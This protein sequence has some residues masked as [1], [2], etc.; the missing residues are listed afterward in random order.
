M[1]IRLVGLVSIEHESEAPRVLAS[2]QAQIALARLCLERPSG[3]GR[4]QLADTI[5]PDGLPSTWASALRSV[6]SR[7]RAS[8]S[9]GASAEPAVIA[10]GGR[11]LLRL[12]EDAQVDVE[13][14]EQAAFTAA[15]AHREGD[16]STAQRLATTSVSL[17]RGPFLAS[18]EGEWVESV[19]RHLKDLRVSALETASS[20]SS[21][22]GDT[23][24]ALRYAAEAVRQAPFRESAYRC[25]MTAHRLAGNRAE[26]LRI[27]Q[28]L[29]VVLAEELG[30]DPSPES[31]AAY[32]GLLDRTRLP[33]A[34]LRTEWETMS[35]H[36]LS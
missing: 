20:S 17:L 6:V 29:R 14:A 28:Q 25:Q 33:G 13:R 7:L 23:H 24:H 16:H 19:R 26:A 12:P 18:H 5:W 35:T 34:P 11:Y 31:E 2:H 30:C 21:A 1:L 9:E 8:L 32:L 15:V 4:E 36:R 10:H 27:Y 22:L 3:I